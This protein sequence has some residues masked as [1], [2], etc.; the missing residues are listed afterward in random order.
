MLQR[1][2]TEPDMALR[3]PYRSKVERRRYDG[4][5]A[6]AYRIREIESEYR[7]ELGG[8][9]AVVSVKRAIR[10]TAEMWWYAETLLA[11]PIRGEAVNPLDV[12]RA[13]GVAARAERR[14]R[15]QAQRVKADPRWKATQR[16][17]EEAAAALREARRQPRPGKSKRT[18]SR[19]RAAERKRRCILRPLGQEA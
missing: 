17:A 11:A 6:S 19:R 7:E 2:T 8:V 10:N 1:A 5:R 14:M 12:L 13:Q 16:A 18:Q 4:N 9:A 3:R 15:Q